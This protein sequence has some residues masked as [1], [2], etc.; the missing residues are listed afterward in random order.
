MEDVK[1]TLTAVTLIRSL[2]NYRLGSYDHVRVLLNDMH[3]QM[4]YIVYTV[5]ASPEETGSGT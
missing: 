1:I 2:K 4:H 3:F 5:S